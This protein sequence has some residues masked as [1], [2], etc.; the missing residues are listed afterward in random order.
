[1]NFLHQLIHSI[2]NRNTPKIKIKLAAIAKNECAYLPEWIAHHLYFGFDDIEVHYNRTS[3]NTLDLVERYKASTAVKF[4]N[5]DEYFYEAAI[6]PQIVLYKQILA[7]AYRD[8]Y[9]HVMFLDIDE[10]WTPRD[11]K[12]SIYSAIVD[13]LEFDSIS[14]E[15]CNKIEDDTPFTNAIQETLSYERALHVKS[16]IRCTSTP[17]Q[18]M[19][20]HNIRDNNLKQCLAD[21][22]LFIAG[23]SAMNERMA[24]ISIDEKNKPLKSSFILHRMY[25][26]Q[27]EFVAGLGKAN[28]EQQVSALQPIKSNRRRGYASNKNSEQI[29]FPVDAFAAYRDC[30]TAELVSSQ[31]T[32][33]QGQQF[34][35]AQY[36]NVL[37]IIENADKDAYKLI[38]ESLAR[39]TLPEVHASLEVLRSKIS[40]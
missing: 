15:W 22:T 28:P 16:I 18:K 34:V 24:Q 12:Q 6:N 21:G 1:M 27:I 7:S 2:K 36:S 38:I 31:D 10:F 14:F 17:P 39:I 29:S 33:K 32:T 13:M 3:D 8:K 35:L 9:S 20:P 5:A 40:S 11:L 26:S 23:E 4:I 19:N 37:N 25:R 30:I